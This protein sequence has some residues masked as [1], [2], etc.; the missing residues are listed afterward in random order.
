MNSESPTVAVIG[1]GPGAM[2]FCHSI[3]TQK[4]ELESKGG[5]TSTFPIIKAFERAEGPGGVWRSDRSHDDNNEYGDRG[6]HDT[7]LYHHHLENTNIAEEKK[8]D[9]PDGLLRMTTTRNIERVTAKAKATPATTNMYAALWTNGPKEAFEFY[10]YTFRDHF[11]DVR[12]PV[13]LPRKHVFGY[14]MARVTRNC[15]DFFERYFRFKTT[16]RN[17]RYLQ[18]IRKFEVSTFDETTN[19]EHVEF[20]DKCIWAAGENGVQNIPKPTLE[21]LEKGSFAGRIIHSSDTSNFKEDVR[22]KT[23]LMIGGEYSAEDLALMA[24]KE[25]VLKVY[26]MTRHAD[27]ASSFNSRYP[28][29]KVEV[30]EEFGVESANGSDITLNKVYKDLKNQKYVFYDDDDKYSKRVLL[31]NIDTVVF[32]TGYKKNLSMLEP[33]LHGALSSGNYVSV[34]KN[35]TPNKDEYSQNLLGERFLKMRPNNNKVCAPYNLC[36]NLYMSTFC[37]DNPNMMYILS[38]IGD[39]PLLNADIVAWMIAKVVSRQISLPSPIEM[40]EENLKTVGRLLQ[41][42]SLRYEMDWI[43]CEEVDEAWETYKGAELKMEESDRM[44]AW[45][46]TG[47]RM[48]RFK[49]PLQFI[50]NDDA[51]NMDEVAW[52]DYAEFALNMERADDECRESL[53]KVVYDTQKGEKDGWMTFRDNFRH[54]ATKSFFTGIR[55]IPLPKPWEELHEDD[56]LW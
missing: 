32:C 23:V 54:G 13:H 47:Q 40:S 12:M 55:P 17:V 19:K 14:L 11:G 22:G 45:M 43:Y 53:D 52:S 5:D 8:D 28:Y 18:D 37:I 44:V 36:D 21:L 56:E 6:D 50:K 27:S 4:K 26:I 35:W 10:D 42:N 3:E 16:V 20:F 41:C 48:L 29:D 1:G 25:G 31:P 24:V 38:E 51:E 7:V 33:A 46:M 2:F 30:L 34:S 49:Y 9:G 39:H 15:P